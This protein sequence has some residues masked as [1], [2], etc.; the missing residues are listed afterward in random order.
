MNLPVC[1]SQ[2]SRNGPFLSDYVNLDRIS[3]FGRRTGHVPSVCQ[4]GLLETGSA[5]VRPAFA[6]Y[7]AAVTCEPSLAG[8]P[9]Q[10]ETCKSLFVTHTRI[11]ATALTPIL[12]AVGVVFLVTGA[13]LAT[14]PL[15]V[16]QQLG[17]GA[18]VVGAV[19]GA[20]FASALLSRL[21]AGRHSDRHGPKAT[22]VVGLCMAALAGFSYLCSS[23]LASQPILALAT[24][25]VGRALLGGGESFIITAGQSWGLT[26]AGPQR[27]ATVI[28]WA[29]T[30][31]YIG[32]A[33]G[34]PMGGLL[35]ERLGFAGI[36]VVTAVIPLFTLGF[37]LPL[38]STSAPAKTGT[39]GGSVISAIL[40]PGLAMSF[41]GF[42]YS[43]MAFFSVLLFVEHG[44]RPSWA[45]FSAFA[46]ALILA[47]IA[48]G[49]LADRL[50]GTRTSMIFMSV[51]IVGLAGVT[52]A[53]NEAI[54]ILASFI[55]GF[56][57]A[58]IYP[59]LGRQAV[60]GLPSSR[61]GTAVAF[62][63][64]FLDLSLALSS[65]VLGLIADSAGLHWVFAASVLASII[66]L[67]IVIAMHHKEAT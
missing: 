21:W 5:V 48:F 40:R 7:A 23:A 37:V 30:A 29:G 8:R 22:M 46:V 3:P 52:L 26:L 50:G 14:L 17:Y 34:G 54:C 38:K 18:D 55:A 64:A 6:I 28:G 12:A 2:M 39:P 11:L 43:S 41:A 31:L 42:G 66:A 16:H 13:S 4:S 9:H 59:A 36:A 49:G 60:R 47:R 53:G 67:M 56:G 25:F 63:S 1:G 24:L 27:A 10:V 15:Y 35:F 32:L 65:P 57:Y 19:A 61:S 45:P 33:A 62:Y 51:Q 58:F 20:Q 44:W